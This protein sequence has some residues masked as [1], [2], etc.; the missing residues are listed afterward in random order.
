MAV[1]VPS[2]HT[3]KLALPKQA[4]LLCQ[5]QGRG[6]WSRKALYHIVTDVA[7]GTLVPLPQG[8]GI[9]RK[10]GGRPHLSVGRS[11]SRKQGSYYACDGATERCADWRSQQQT[12]QW[13]TACK[14]LLSGKQDGKGR[15]RM[16]KGTQAFSSHQETMQTFSGSSPTGEPIPL[17][18]ACFSTLSPSKT[19]A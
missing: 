18:W 2:E 17:G 5:P 8:R 4:Q 15:K 10:I 11:E 19:H 14:G 6:P 12:H 9:L 1:T 7:G 13:E 3:M 16:M